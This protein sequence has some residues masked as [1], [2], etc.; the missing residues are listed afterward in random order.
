M[1]GDKHNRYSGAAQKPAAAA[2]SNS[3]ATEKLR[4][5]PYTGK[6]VK[7]WQHCSMRIAENSA[8]TA[9]L[10]DTNKWST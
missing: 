10:L 3:M 7:Q 9:W 8:H 5:E 1:R 4:L 2:K 6:N